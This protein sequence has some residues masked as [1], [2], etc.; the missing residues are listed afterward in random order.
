VPDCGAMMGT[1]ET[2]LATKLGVAPGSTLA[3]LYA[4]AGWA[5][6]LPPGVVMKR[7]ARGHADV[8]LAFFTRRAAFAGRLDALG[9]VIFPS[10]GLWIAWPKRAAQM[11]TDLTD[12]AVRAT[13]LPR[14]LV[15][16]KVC[17]VDAT[18]TALRLVW[19][20]EHRPG[21]GGGN[22]GPLSENVARSNR[23]GPP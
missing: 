8:I 21:S 3:L 12:D 4:P 14:G 13:A 23:A 7:Q 16:N 22:V 9:R 19:R 1:S 2:P 11:A 17:A 20:R 15:D 5:C 18:W 10:G 6:E